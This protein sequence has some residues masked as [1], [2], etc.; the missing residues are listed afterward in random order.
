[1]FSLDGIC[2]VHKLLMLT[3]EKMLQCRKR[4]CFLDISKTRE[5]I[6]GENNHRSIWSDTKTRILL[7]PIQEKSITDY[8]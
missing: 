7:D 4:F 6:A 8:F 3:I 2:F 1:M 5:S